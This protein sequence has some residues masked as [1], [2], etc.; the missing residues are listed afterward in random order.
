MLE[1][2]KHKPNY[3]GRKENVMAVKI[4]HASM[5]ERGRIRGGAAGDQTGREVCTRDWYNKPWIAV[6]RPKDSGVAEK[7]AKAMEAACAN[8]NI[9]YDQSQ[10][11]TL[12]A[13][14]KEN[15]WNIAGIKTK[16]ETDCSALV[17][18]CV[19]AAGIAV[20]KDMYT[21]NEQ[22]SL[23]NTGKFEIHTDSSYTGKADKLKRGDILLGKG[24]TAIVLS[25][26]VAA[27]A[28]GNSGNNCS[29]SN[30]V[31]RTDKNLSG[32]YTTTEN[33]NMRNG[34]GTGY[35]IITTIPK[36]SKVTCNG[37][38]STIGNTKWLRIQY[39]GKK[40]YC[41]GNYLHK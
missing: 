27:G 15:G 34:A 9:G 41:S 22:Q 37:E 2:N 36:G 38:Y 16:C 6:I 20:S 5:D 17:A 31:T 35:S 33:L 8:D 11:T 30:Y 32:T 40:G 4:G 18:V 13:L 3:K 24:H 21:G 7:I 26:G 25:N 10:R 14:A 19:N 39:G 28:M 12:F 1:D 29:K 23:A